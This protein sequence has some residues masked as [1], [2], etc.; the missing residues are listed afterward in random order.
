M[1]H[2]PIHL[3]LGTSAT[4]APSKLGTIPRYGIPEKG[5][6]KI[7]RWWRETTWWQQSRRIREQSVHIWGEMEGSRRIALKKIMSYYEEN[8]FYWLDNVWEL[9]I[10]GYIE[11]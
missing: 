1:Y 7:Q 10:V 6:E 3:F 5:E 8:D 9:T 11:N 4:C 2:L